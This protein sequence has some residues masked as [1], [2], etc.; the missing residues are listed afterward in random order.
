[1]SVEGRRGAAAVA[2]LVLGSACGLED[3]LLQRTAREAEARRAALCPECSI[4]CLVTDQPALQKTCVLMKE[5]S[6]MWAVKCGLTSCRVEPP[7]R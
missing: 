1:M 7:A 6:V 4:F 5:H 2:V 3:R